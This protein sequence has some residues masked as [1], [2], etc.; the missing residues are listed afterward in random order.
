VSAVAD[1]QVAV[2]IPCFND[3]SL[4]GQTIASLEDPVPMEV[5]VVD[6]HSSD[7]TAGA[8]DELAGEGVRILHHDS[9]RGV[10]AARNTGLAA[11]RAPFV[12]PLDADDLAT[13]GALPVMVEALSRASDAV[14]AYGDYREFGEHDRLR[15]VP[16]T[17]D[18]YRLV[19]TNEYPPTALWR[20]RL[21]EEVGGWCTRRLAGGYYYEDWDLWMTVAERG[22]RG[23][24]MGRGFETYRQRVHG[25]RLLEAAK[26]HHVPI[27]QAMRA[28]HPQLF[29]RLAHHRIHSGLSPARKRLYPVV[30]GGR[31]RFGFEPKVKEAL[32]RIGVWTLRR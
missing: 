23:I 22:E 30:Y 18:P 16:E 26:R 21:L 27:Y 24:H 14:V 17:I 32:D 8:V 3:G 6:D 15:A 11:T 19:F 7:G 13:P 5:V 2:I 10:A 12:F 9:N 31:R 29:E 25:P 1:P 4:V 28:D 20:R